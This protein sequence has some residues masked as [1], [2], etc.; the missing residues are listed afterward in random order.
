MKKIFLILI[1][2]ISTLT[3][4]QKPKVDA[5]RYKE[6][7]TTQRDALTVPSGEHWKVYNITTGQFEYWDGDSWEPITVIGAGTGNVIKVGT[8]VDNQIG[9]WTGDGTIEGSPKFRFN[10]NFVA[11][12]EIGDSSENGSINLYGDSGANGGFINIWNSTGNNTTFQRW[13]LKSQNNF[14]IAADFTGVALQI[15]SATLGITAPATTTANITTLGDKALITKEYADANYSSSS[16]DLTNIQQYD[17]LTHLKPLKWIGTQAQYDVDFP[18]G[19][20]DREVIILDATPPVLNA[21]DI[22]VD[23]SGFSG[24]LSATDIDVQTALSTLDALTVSSG[25]V[26]KSDDGDGFTVTGS[27]ASLFTTIGG[28]GSTDANMKLTGVGSF[29]S[30]SVNTKA[31]YIIDAQNP[32]NRAGLEPGTGARNFVFPAASGTLALTSDLTEFGD[33][34]KVGTPVANQSTYW[35]GDGTIAGEAANTYDPTTNTLKII[36]TGSAKQTLLDGNEVFIQSLSA[37]ANVKL[38]STGLEVDN[39]A[40]TT[41][42]N[43]NFASTSSNATV[44]I[45]NE[46]GTVALLSDTTSEVIQIACSD[47]VTDLTTGTSKAYF[48]MPYAATLNDVRCSL[49]DAGTVTGLTIDINENGVSVLSTL[50]TT[51][52]TEDTSTT[53]TTAAVISDSALADDAKITIDFDAVPTAGK[54][55]IVTLKVTRL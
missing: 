35:T 24:N 21:T 40:L 26:T 28:T 34:S 41:T 53:A 19:H 8:P 10:D 55:V 2:C 45:K 31:F 6:L 16:I 54:G 25:D 38:T 22:V 44:T 5:V 33:V 9:V 23:A 37:N 18:A 1:L 36:E 17:P 51:D 42:T 29:A 20:G 32:L 4:A 30:A 48:R 50:L 47:L 39:T 52:A 27:G 7:T 14:Q 46:T 43:L 12:L 49:L 15:D 3:Y 11:T 13:S